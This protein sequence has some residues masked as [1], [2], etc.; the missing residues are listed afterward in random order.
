M[1]RINGLPVYAA[2]LAAG[3][4]GVLRVS[5]VED[6]AVQSNFDVFKA[7]APGQS[8][9]ALYAVADEDRHLVRGVVLRADFPIYR[10]DTPEDPGYY[11]IFSAAQIRQMAEK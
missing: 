7:V 4:D 11:V 10:K 2:T 1:K 3:A 6:P 9:R 8:A 5:L